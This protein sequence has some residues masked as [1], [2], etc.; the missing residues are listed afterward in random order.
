MVGFEPH[1]TRPKSE[2]RREWHGR[3]VEKRTYPGRRSAGALESLPPANA[4]H[5]ERGRP[6]RA[7]CSG[8]IDLEAGREVLAWKK[9]AA[10]SAEGRHDGQTKMISSVGRP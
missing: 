3:H 10:D 2:K 6:S 4:S 7:K 5:P 8:K 1:V 9:L